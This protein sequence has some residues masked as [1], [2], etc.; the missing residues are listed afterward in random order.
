VTIVLFI[1]F[2]SL[3]YELFY[4]IDSEFEFVDNY[5]YISYTDAIIRHLTLSSL[6]FIIQIVG[7]LLIK[8]VLLGD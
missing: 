8:S 1:V 5:E 7:M 2:V 3:F 6:V 4:Y